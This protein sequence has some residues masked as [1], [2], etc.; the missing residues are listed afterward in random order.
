MTQQTQQT[1]DPF[2]LD[3]IEQAQ[4]LADGETGDVVINS[5]GDSGAGE[6]NGAGESGAEAGAA[7]N[8]NATDGA[9]GADGD[10]VDGANG[11]SQ[12][13]QG[14]QAQVEQAG[15]SGKP[16]GVSSKK[17]DRVLPYSALQQAREEARQS[18]LKL[19]EA[20]AQLE[21]LKSGT[22]AK[23]DKSGDLVDL[24]EEELQEIEQDFPQLAKVAKAARVATQRLAEME[25]SNGKGTAQQEAPASTQAASPSDDPIQDAIDTVP[26]LLTWQTDPKHAD[27][28]ARAID[29]DNLLKSSPKWANKPLEERF[30]EATRRVKEEFD[31]AQSTASQEDIDQQQAVQQRTQEA[32][33]KAEA[34]P[35]RTPNTLSDLNG[36]AR[37]AVD[38]IASLTPTAMLNRMLKMSHD[39]IMSQL[40]RGG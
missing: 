6:G 33:R 12:Q 1:F 11:T 22:A 27:K 28:F 39:E 35:R 34:A 13:E 15:E 23:P 31:L 17:G 37:P 26:D 7:A 16:V 3:A 24:T 18:K 8:A 30:A 20:Q 14:T 10:G 5:D 25:R 19:A 32:Q 21:A 2:D 38:Q 36:G 29:H 9:A 40:E 4:R